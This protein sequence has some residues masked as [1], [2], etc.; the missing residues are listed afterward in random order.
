MGTTILKYP[1]NLQKN[2][3]INEKARGKKNN[4]Y[5]TPQL[6]ELPNFYSLYNNRCFSSALTSKIWKFL[7]IEYQK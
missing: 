3:C 5:F 4:A 6:P 7:D 2:P 1:Q